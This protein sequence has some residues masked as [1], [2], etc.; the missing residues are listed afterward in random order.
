MMFQQPVTTFAYQ[1][2]PQPAVVPYG[3]LPFVAQSAYLQP[4]YHFGPVPRRVETPEEKKTREE[5]EGQLDAELFHKEKEDGLAAVRNAANRERRNRWR[6]KLLV[7]TQADRDHPDPW[8]NPYRDPGHMPTIEEIDRAQ[9]HD[10]RREIN[11]QRTHNNRIRQL[12]YE[13]QRASLPAYQRDQIVPPPLERMVKV[14]TPRPKPPKRKQ[15]PPKRA[16]PQGSLDIEAQNR[17]WKGFQSQLARQGHKTLKEEMERQHKEQRKALKK[18][19][20]AFTA[21]PQ[22]DRPGYFHG[23]SFDPDLLR[24]VPNME[25]D[26]AALRDPV[27]ARAQT[28]ILQNRARDIEDRIRK[29][30][31]TQEHFKEH[32]AR[33]LQEM[34]E[35][36]R[37]RRECFLYDAAD[38]DDHLVNFSHQQRRVPHPNAPVTQAS[39]VSPEE[40]EIRRQTRAPPD[41]AGS[42]APLPSLWR[43]MKEWLEYMTSYPSTRVP[44]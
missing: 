37:R 15:Q 6:Q 20:D 39:P 14:Q 35:Q 29:L 31:E 4:S 9:R 1:G 41:I 16:P 44:I 24:P 26:E 8:D 33:E 3:S 22:S 17:Q 11:R 10:D 5:L 38:A 13:L 36:M 2:N 18:K 42:G 7:L 32:R 40:Q 19:L 30:Q 43:N 12:N 25:I 27:R 34:E 21:P 23:P 28:L